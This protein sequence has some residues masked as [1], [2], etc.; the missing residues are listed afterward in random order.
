VNPGFGEARMA[1]AGLEADLGLEP[2]A[3]GDLQACAAAPAWAPA[4]LWSL[5]RLD[6]ARGRS[7]AASED[8]KRY[9]AAVARRAALA[10]SDA[11]R[12]RQVALPYE[13]GLPLGPDP[14]GKDL[15]AIHD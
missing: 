15:E 2:Q 12:G 7:A 9:Y 10:A 14:E 11:A 8:L 13:P 6:A 3:R 1:R 5:R 4:A